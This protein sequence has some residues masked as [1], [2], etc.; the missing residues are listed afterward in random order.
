MYNHYAKFVERARTAANPSTLR[1]QYSQAGD[2]AQAN[3]LGISK[4]AGGQPG[5]A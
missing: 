5:G 1:Y 4:A 2:P 3:K